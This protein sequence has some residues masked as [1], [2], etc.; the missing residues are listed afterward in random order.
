MTAKAIT[1][2]A[3]RLNWFVERACALLVGAM[4]VIIWF[5]VVERYFLELGATWTEELS[6]YVM[7]WAAL[8]AVSCGAYYR[9]HIGLELFKQ[10][11]PSKAARTLVFVLDVIALVFFLFLTY[12]GIGMTASGASQ[13]ATIFGMTMVVPFAAVPVSSALT[14]FQVFA[15]MFRISD[16]AVDQAAVRGQRP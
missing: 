4:V 3:S 7:I 15:A 6:R 13:Y 1:L 8:L 11:L 9:E 10:Y 16:T 14:A 12:Y 2:C 5:E